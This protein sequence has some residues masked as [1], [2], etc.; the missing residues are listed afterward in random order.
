MKTK[1]IILGRGLPVIVSL[2]AAYAALLTPRM[3]RAQGLMLANP[4]WNITLSDFGYSDFLLDNTPGFEGREYLSGEWGAAIAYQP[5]GSGMLAP[6]F[7]DPMFLFP[8]WATLSTFGTKTPLVQ[9]GLNADNLPIAQSVITN[10]HLEITLRQ[11]ML[12]TIVG[13]PMGTVAAS[14]GGAGAALNSSRYVLKQ[15][16]T[17]RNTSGTALTNVQF[18]QFLHGLNAQHGVYDSRNYTG[19]LSGFRYDTTMAG[20]DPY[21]IAAGSSTNGLEDFIGFHATAAPSA[22]E[23]GYYGIEGNGVDDHFSGKPSEGVHLSIENN[24]LTPP[25]SAREGT[26]HFAPSNRWVS[27]TQR[28]NLGNLAA[29]QSAS[30]DVLLSIR[31]GTRV[32]TGTNMPG[33]CNG[34]SSVPGG[35]DYE[36]EDVSSP[37][38]C[39]GEYSKADPAEI[40]IRIAQGE[41]EPFTFLTPGGPA[42]VWK[43]QFSGGFN[44]NVNL[45]F[46]YDPTVLPQGFDET[47][48]VLY[49]FSAGAWQ[50]LPSTVDVV[51][52][53][54]TVATTNF[55]VFALGTEPLAAYTVSASETPSNSGTITGAGTY[56]GSASATLVAAPAS[57]YV[58]ANWTEGGST[59]STSPSYT[60]IVTS[61]RTLVANFVPVGEAKSISTSSSPANGGTTSGDGAYAPGSSATVGATP[62]YGYKFS[63]WQ[64]NGVTVSST[65]NYTFTVASNRVLVAKFKPVCYVIV[66]SEPAIG[67]DVEADPAY[68]LNEVAKLKAIPNAGWSFVNWT[69]NGLPVSTDPN[70]QFTVTG[71]R[72]LVGNFA[73]GH[74]IEAIAEP[75]NG[76][77]AAG[78]GVYP[79]G[80]PVWLEAVAKPGYVF[81]DWT[82]GGFS[83]CSDP[84]FSFNS[85]ANHSLVANFIALPPLTTLIPVP[86]ALTICWPA[87]VNTWLLQQ[88]SELGSTNWV[89]LTNTVVA[90]QC[91]VTVPTSTG[92]GFFRLVHP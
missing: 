23:I 36:F 22:L 79:D 39:F 30:L 77:T 86:G 28:W 76:G 87:G 45:K 88:C 59:A 64:V 32:S 55:G 33:G 42:Q 51:L 17:I 44:G 13:T 63:K 90:G 66:S 34:G 69:Q 18:F 85:D 67:G 5:A 8:D 9:T 19:A 54:I 62:N 40:E 26:D 7:L 38:S 70:F 11:E 92:S 56:A 83:V 3:V 10:S 6:R 20:V 4:H 48:L 1:Q 58:F 81:V 50:S 49:E 53:T 27:G 65:R 78:A 84:F 29:G 57:G 60:F 73:P 75:A 43:V 14:A 35:L 41:F 74:R 71:N 21:A 80:D 82:E 72:T 89:T 52:H 68:E 16:A 2:L 61:D 46:A 31:T 25:Y 91:Q 15:T 24:W 37:G 12:D 47:T